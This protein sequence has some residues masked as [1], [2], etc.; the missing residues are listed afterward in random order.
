[1]P[2]V[3]SVE[4]FARKVPTSMDAEIN[5][6]LMR[7]AGALLARRP[8][9]RGEL[10]E[11]LVRIAG[12]SPAESVLDRLEQLNLL[13]D[14][15]YAYNFALCRIKQDGWGPAKVQNALLRRQI[16]VTIIEGALERV[17]T[18]LGGESAL[19]SYLREYCGKR[20]PPSDV[21]SLRKLISHLLRRGF[22]EDSISAALRQIVPGELWRQFESGE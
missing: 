11:K 19:D 20:K 18:E 3:K 17:R 8:Y 7:K 4:P 16:R 1:M 13:N 6:L 9:S 12:A 10:R 5:K 21:K 2:I 22:D 14:A 15:D